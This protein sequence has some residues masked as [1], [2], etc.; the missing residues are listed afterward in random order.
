MARKEVSRCRD[1]EFTR[2]THERN[3]HPIT[4]CLCVGGETAKERRN[5]KEKRRRGEEE[6]EV[7]HVESNVMPCPRRYVHYTITIGTLPWPLSV[8]LPAIYPP[9]NDQK[10]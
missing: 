8:H 7:D 4:R 3:L 6:E 2:G 5:K 9:P 1:V 10:C